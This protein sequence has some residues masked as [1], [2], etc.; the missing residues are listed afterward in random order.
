MHGFPHHHCA[1]GIRIGTAADIPFVSAIIGAD[2]TD[3]MARCTT[4]LTPHGGFLLEPIS[5]SVLE[6]HMFFRREGRGRQ[7]FHAAREGLR[8][9]FTELR[10]L[11]V[12]GRIPLSDRP[13]RLFTRMIGF[14]SDGVRPHSNGGEPVEW[15]EMRFDECPE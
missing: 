10:A 6:A 8:Y 7:A 3:A 2:A 12:F 5:S 15:F 11:V 9:C 13:A 14:R 1:Q 4:L